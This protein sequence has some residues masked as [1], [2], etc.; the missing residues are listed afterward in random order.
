MRAIVTEQPSSGGY[1]VWA[2]T[3][4]Y[5]NLPGDLPGEA[6][7]KKYADSDGKGW[8]A[9]MEAAYVVDLV[10]DEEGPLGLKARLV[11]DFADPTPLLGVAVRKGVVPVETVLAGGKVRVS[12][13]STRAETELYHVAHLGLAPIKWKRTTKN[14]DKCTQVS[15]KITFGSLSFKALPSSNDIYI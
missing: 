7:E 9:E 5:A 1:F 2:E 3:T 15:N 12:G 6:G 13:S 8:E 14:T 10:G 11:Q 4:M